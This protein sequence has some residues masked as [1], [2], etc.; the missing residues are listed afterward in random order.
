MEIA[1]VPERR[2]RETEP[3]NA[4]KYHHSIT[5]DLTKNTHGEMEPNAGKYHLYAEKGATLI[6]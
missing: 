6:A 1:G 2:C 3:H 5:R 4:G